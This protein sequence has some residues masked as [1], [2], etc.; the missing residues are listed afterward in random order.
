[1]Q[2]EERKTTV[3]KK[4]SLLIDAQKKILTALIAKIFYIQ[5]KYEFILSHWKWYNGVG[6]QNLVGNTWANFVLTVCLI[7]FFLIFKATGWRNMIDSYG[8]SSTDS[9]NM[10]EQFYKNLFT[11]GRS[12]K[13]VPRQWRP[14]DFFKFGNFT[15]LG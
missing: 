7:F 3:V 8:Y 10:R 15:S 4:S 11:T 6:N 2:K 14:V 1:M 5:N 13:N 12:V 9:E